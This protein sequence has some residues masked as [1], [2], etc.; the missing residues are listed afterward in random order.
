MTDEQKTSASNW[1]SLVMEQVKSVGVPTVALGVM[2][3][4]A[5][6]WGIWLRGEFKS[7]IDNNT[8]ALSSVQVVV[9]GDTKARQ[10]LSEHLDRIER[11]KS[12]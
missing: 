6:D 10:E 7:V 4:F 1:L 8:K 3:W 2:F 5:N 9:E 11:N 12:Q